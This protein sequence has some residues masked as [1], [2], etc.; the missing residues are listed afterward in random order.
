MTRTYF[1]GDDA[2]H[3][4][5]LWQADEL[6][7]QGPGEA[8]TLSFSVAGV[9]LVADLNPAGASPQ[10]L[11]AVGGTPV[12]GAQAGAT[13]VFS[14]NDGRHGRQLW[15]SDGWSSNTRMATD[16][17]PGPAGSDP[18][19]ITAAGQVAYFSAYDRAHG[20][21]LWKLTVPPAPQMFLLGPLAPVKTG[22]PVTL[23]ATMQPAPGAPQPAGGVTFFENG[24]KIGARPLAPQ[25]SGG[26][27]ASLTIAAPSGT[28]QIVAVY[29]GDGDYLPA[30][31]N[32]SPLTGN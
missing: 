12:F 13:E 21:E 10:D 24:T 8:G 5:Q 14:A 18:Q 11:T 30:T 9:R 26:R 4:R 1:A 27:A 32:T 20:R 25:P 31:S 2:G 19:D 16:I 15:Y 6:V 22:S 3:G 7:I 29:S 17:N 28:H 23:T